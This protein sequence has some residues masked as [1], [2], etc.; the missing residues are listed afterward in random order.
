MADTIYSEKAQSMAEIRQWDIDFSDDL[1]T[2]VIVV[3]A[4][5]THVPP[6]GTASTPTVG[7]ISG[8]IVPV[9]LGPL[10]V[11]GVHTLDVLATFSDGEKSGIRIYIP[12]NY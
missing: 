9:L 12:V 10:S 7:V 1:N 3:S 2:G 4:V 6:S 11:T 5:A 8:N